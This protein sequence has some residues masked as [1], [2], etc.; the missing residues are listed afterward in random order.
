MP[1]KIGSRFKR[2]LDPL[3]WWYRQELIK[4]L[5]RQSPSA[6]KRTR[7]SMSL[8]H[9][10]VLQEVVNAGGHKALRDLVR[11]T[12][13]SKSGMTR[14]VQRLVELKLVTKRK[15]AHKRDYNVEA[16]L[17]GK[18]LCAD[19]EKGVVSSLEMLLGRIPQRFHGKMLESVEKLRAKLI[20]PRFGGLI[21]PKGY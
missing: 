10:E 14:V 12:E 4:S 3:F 1:D 15:V 13:F 18:Q 7:P 16:T 9:Y 21:G 5:Q 17:S 19:V 6:K 8:A 2:E 20:F 11:Y